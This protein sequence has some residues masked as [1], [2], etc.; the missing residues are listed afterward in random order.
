M[1]SI[2]ASRAAKE[3][4]KLCEEAVVLAIA[5]SK[6]NLAIVESHND[7]VKAWTA[8]KSQFEANEE[9]RFTER[10]KVIEKYEANFKTAMDALG[11][12]RSTTP[13]NV[14]CSGDWDWYAD[15]TGCTPYWYSSKECVLKQS[16]KESKARASLGQKPAAYEIRNFTENKPQTPD[17]TT[18][19]TI[20]CCTNISNI[21]GSIL[22]ETN[23]SQLNTCVKTLADKATQDAAA[24]PA[25]EKAA[26]AKAA[27]AAAAAKVNEAAPTKAEG[28][29]IAIGIMILILLLCSSV[30]SGLL[31]VVNE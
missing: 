28:M 15:H 19:P 14:N 17:Q 9:T 20:T 31:F 11:N 1:S 6:G 7:E 12:E 10:K 2:E 24:K 3:S 16:V 26:A 25:D 21:I 22:T 5:I 18:F 4:A 13:C 8:M 30:I 23:I 27:Q 29:L